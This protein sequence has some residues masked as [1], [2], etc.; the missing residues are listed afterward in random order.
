MEAEGGEDGY[1]FP[2]PQYPIP[3]APVWATWIVLFLAWFFLGSSV[4]FTVL[5]G[6]PLNVAALILAVVCLTRGGIKTGVLVLVLG[7]IGSVIVYLTG[8]L[9]FL[10]GS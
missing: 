10:T 6:L 9:M 5:I 7:T 1:G 4:P 3:K 2:S 8:L